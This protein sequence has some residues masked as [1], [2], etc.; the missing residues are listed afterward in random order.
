MLAIFTLFWVLSAFLVMPFGVRTPEEAGVD[1]VPGQVHSAPANFSPRRIL[2]RATILGAIL[3][4]V[5][6]QNY[7]HGWITVGDLDILPWMGA[8]R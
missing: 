8:P 7:I 6:Y 2:R 1:L 5:Y 3:F 4:V